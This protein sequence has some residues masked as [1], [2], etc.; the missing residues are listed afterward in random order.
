MS[1][2]HSEFESFDFE[3]LP[4]PQPILWQVSHY[5]IITI[6]IIIIETVNRSLCHC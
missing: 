1:Q 2:T 3:Y 5:F 6:N 4:S